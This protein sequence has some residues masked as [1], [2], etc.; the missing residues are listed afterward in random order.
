MEK[1]KLAEK[2]KNVP[3]QSEI[4]IKPSEKKD[5]GKPVND[6]REMSTQ[7]MQF[8]QISPRSKKDSVLSKKPTFGDLAIRTSIA[9][10]ENQ[11]M[12]G[13]NLE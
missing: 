4:E 2:L 1:P 12:F 10:G 6:L 5:K 11:L 13:K 3:R 8:N 9:S 7:S